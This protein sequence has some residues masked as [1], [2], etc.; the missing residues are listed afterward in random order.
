MPYTTS[1]AC[2]GA[3]P[4]APHTHYLVP[5]PVLGLALCRYV[6]GPA[7]VPE[8]AQARAAASRELPLQHAVTLPSPPGPA[9]ADGGAAPA[10]ADGRGGG[11]G[12]TAATADCGDGNGG[13]GGAVAEQ[14]GEGE[15]EGKGDEDGEG[16]GATFGIMLLQTGNVDRPVR[17][18]LFDT[19]LHAAIAAAL[20]SAAA[21]AGW[22]GPPPAPTPAARKAAA[23]AVSDGEGDEEEGDEEEEEEEEEE[24]ME[25]VVGDGGDED[26][27][28]ALEL[29]QVDALPSFAAAAAACD[30]PPPAQQGG[31][32]GAEVDGQ[33]PR[34]HLEAGLV[35]KCMNR[36]LLQLKK[37]AAAD[38]DGCAASALL[39]LPTFG[40]E[41]EEEDELGPSHAGR[42][43]G[44]GCAVCVCGELCVWVGR[45]GM[46][47]SVLRGGGGMERR[48][49]GWVGAMFLLMIEVRGVG[50]G[51]M[52]LLMIEVQGVGVGGVACPSRC[53][54]GLVPAKQPSGV[55]PGVRLCHVTD[56]MHGH[57]YCMHDPSH[58][59]PP[60]PHPSPLPLPPMQRAP[61]AP[62]CCA[63]VNAREEP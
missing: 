18:P 43:G 42:A 45:G 15:R 54:H 19:A 57:L 49:E 8:A 41:V 37:R 53:P 47:R 30:A 34:N 32:G 60:H 35:I 48:V 23:G 22:E 55:L 39:S 11:G 46:G 20:A 29:M 50:V 59:P 7:G 44:N 14:D 63:G 21:S 9:A 5:P 38:P 1:S 52:F 24:E 62:P 40:E 3:S 4:P 27:M 31:C 13:V 2:P 61:P 25:G 56:P 12:G 33:L 28:R 26:S 10:E 17:M 16:E 51:G 58:P 6:P 36:W